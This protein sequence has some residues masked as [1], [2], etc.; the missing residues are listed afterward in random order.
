MHFL[1]GSI[2]ETAQVKQQLI[3]SK[4]IVTVSLTTA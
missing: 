1:V 4:I 3:L 2:F